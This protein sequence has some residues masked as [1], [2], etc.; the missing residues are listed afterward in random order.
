MKTFLKILLV[1]ALASAAHAKEIKLLNVSYDP[2]RELYME[3]NAAF[4][5]YWKD[6]YK[7]QKLCRQCDGSLNTGRCGQKSARIQ[8]RSFRQLHWRRRDLK[9]ISKKQLTSFVAHG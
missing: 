7:R 9:I 1:V 6:V 5:N 2:T 4:A 3:Y 8:V